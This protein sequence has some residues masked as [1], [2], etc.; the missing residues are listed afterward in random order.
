MI[1]ALRSWLFGGGATELKKPNAPSVRAAHVASAELAVEAWARSGEGPGKLAEYVARWIDTAVHTEREAC[2]RV[3]D[4]I[5]YELDLRGDLGAG[6]AEHCA[7]RI[8]GRL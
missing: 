5:E 4:D 1:G 2:A 3:C 6:A 8:R 7:Q